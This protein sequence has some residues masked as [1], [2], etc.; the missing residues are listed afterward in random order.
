MYIKK[1]HID[2]FGPLR[3]KEL[4]LCDGLNIIEGENESGKSTVAMFIKFMLYGLSG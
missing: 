3:D 1:I 2:S 4:E